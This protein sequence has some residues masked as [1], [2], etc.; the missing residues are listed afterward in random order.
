MIPGSALDR[1]MEELY[2]G[3]I[4][5][6]RATVVRGR[7]P[8]SARPGDTAIVL[9]DGRI[10]GFVGGVCAESTVRLQALRSLRTGEPLLLRISPDAGRTPDTDAGVDGHSEE[11][12][13]LTV[14]NPCL[15]GGELEIF[16]E[17]LLP[18]TRIVVVGQAPIAAALVALGP[19][20][21]YDVLTIDPEEVSETALSDTAAVVVASHG[22]GEEDALTLA[23]HLGIPYVALV[24]S[25]KR[26]AAVLAGLDLSD[27]E[28]VSIHDPAGLWIGAESPGE[29]AVSILAE[30]I[31]ARHGVPVGTAA[32]A[33]AESPAASGAT[34]EPP[35]A[36]DPVCG[37]TVAVVP[38]TLHSD[39]NGVRHWFCRPG[40]REAYAGDP[41]R[42]ASVDA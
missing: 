41:A 7:R 13:T 17:P 8:T 18:P 31:A 14:A 34:A 35:T 5:F 12:G 10:E 2:T 37:M 9:A 25:R 15:S 16:L 22:R 24:S 23:V 1:R 40:C 27:E 38:E 20:L 33:P 4:P 21:E 30:F 42:Y 39:V 28:R 26:G 11:D 32:D 36:I 3:R 6:V 29:I 19:V